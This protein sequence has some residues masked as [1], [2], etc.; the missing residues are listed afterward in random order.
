M[1]RMCHRQLF[2]TVGASV[3]AIGLGQAAT[4]A[5]AAYQ[6]GTAPDG[7]DQVTTHLTVNGNLTVTSTG[8]IKVGTRVIADSG[9]VF[10]AP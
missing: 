5:E 8:Q 7:G 4:P 6:N 2:K 1:R 3:A 9:G 10:Y